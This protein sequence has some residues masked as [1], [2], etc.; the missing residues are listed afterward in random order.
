MEVK[1]TVQD[2]VAF[3]E[4]IAAEFNAGHIKAPIHLESGNEQQLINLFEGDINEDDWVFCSWRA[5]LKCLLKGVTPEQLKQEILAGHSMGLCFPEYKILSSAIVG[6]N[7]PIAL[8]VAMGIKRNGGKNKVVC[9]IGDMTSETGIYYECRK[10]AFRQKLPILW[11]IED[12]GKSTNTP[13]EE[14]WGKPD[15]LYV[16][17]IDYYYR[18]QSKWPHSGTGTFINF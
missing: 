12:N 13:T 11:V 7:C 4:D 9:F 15:Y 18:Y 16:G 10:Y 6:G 3:E 8:G 2:L 1:L 17:G 14:A 5:H